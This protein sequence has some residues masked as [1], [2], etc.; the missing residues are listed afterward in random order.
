[1][2]LHTALERFLLGCCN[3]FWY[4]HFKKDVKKLEKVQKRNIKKRFERQRKCS[5]MTDLQAPIW[6]ASQKEDQEVI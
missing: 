5:T 6:L 2:F 4:L 1:M 3:Q